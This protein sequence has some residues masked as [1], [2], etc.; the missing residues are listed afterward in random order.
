MHLL[1]TVRAAAFIQDLRGLFP[2]TATCSDATIVAEK[3]WRTRAIQLE[4]QLHDLQTL[5]N[6]E[7]TGEQLYT[8]LFAPVAD[9]S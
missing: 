2:G 1:F 4:E 6:S 3:A 8:V 9:G 5:S 7:R